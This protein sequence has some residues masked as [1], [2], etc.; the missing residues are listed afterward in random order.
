MGPG[1]TF[2]YL[3]GA[4]VVKALGARAE[5][6]GL[7]AKDARPGRLALFL[8]VQLAASFMNPWFHEGALYPVL[9][10]LRAGKDWSSGGLYMRIVELQSPFQAALSG[11]F[12]VVVL[13][14]A[15]AAAVVGYALSLGEKKARLEH[16][17]AAILLVGSAWSYLRNLPFAALGLSLPIAHGCAALGRRL[18]ARREP[19]RWVALAS[20]ACAA[21]ITA[22]AA[23]ADELHGNSQYVAR[24]G[25]GFSDFLRYDEACDFLDRSPPAG[26]L[27]N[28]FG[29]GHF[30]LFKRDRKSP[31]PYICGNTELYPGKFLVEY[32]DIV[33][34]KIPYGPIFAE[35]N[36]TDAL[37]DHRVEVSRE[38]IAAF[39]QDPAWR[40]VYADGHCVD[41]RKVDASTPPAVDLDA[42]AKSYVFKDTTEDDFPLTRALRKIGIL[43]RREP[44]PIEK[45]HVACLLDT[46]G[47]RDQALELAKQAL[48]ERP[49][50]PAVLYI[51]ASL[52]WRTNP[53]DAETHALEFAKLAPNDPHGFAVAGQA[54]QARHDYALAASYFEKA[55][56]IDPGFTVAQVNVLASYLAQEPPDLVAL[57]RALARPGI[58]EDLHAFYE[59]H[60]FAIDNR[61]ADAEKSFREACSKHPGFFVPAHW[62]LARCLGRRGAFADER[63]ELEQVVKALPR[64][65]GAWLDLGVARAHAGDRRDGADALEIAATLLPR[66][67]RP[68]VERGL[69]AVDDGDRA[70]AERCYAEANARAPHSRDVLRLQARLNEMPK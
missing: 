37:L 51:L 57:K 10:V 70:T 66:D 38:L 5:K 36:I 43:P 31:L 49:D 22:R 46:L 28:N 50:L 21:L 61:P 58:P 64:D 53:K 48:A 32:H 11:V 27:F 34:A 65:G 26:N 1:V 39:A 13:K 60:A 41:Y 55:L 30:L 33:S 35:R 9:V 45:L 19:L 54:A 15:I 40:L 14:A 12:E 29:A 18:G 67:A 20:L 25:L 23:L 6:V 52:E 47:R 2:A 59:G 56:A 69:I 68:L 17:V 16:L 8:G 42:F 3:V 4:L 44:I 62:E 7:D 63:A 24:A